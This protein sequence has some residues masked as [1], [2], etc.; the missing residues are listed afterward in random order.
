MNAVGLEATLSVGSLIV[1]DYL[2]KITPIESGYMMAVTK[3]N[4]TQT[5]TVMDGQS[6]YQAAVA[7]G[8]QGTEAEFEAE[9]AK[10]AE[11]ASAEASRVQAEQERQAAEK[12]R[13]TA[14]QSRV[15]AEQGRVTAEQSR[16]AAEAER[17]TAEQSR[18]TAEGARK[19]AESARAAAETHREE[20]ESARATAEAGRAAAE[21]LRRSAET[22]RGTAE[23]GRVTAEQVRTSAEQERIGAEAE[24][25]TAENSRVGAETARVVAEQTR[26]AEFGEMSDKFDNIQVKVEPVENGALITLTDPK[27]VT[28][29]VTISKAD[30]PR[31][32]VSG[33]GGAVPAL[34]RLWDSVGKTST[35]GTDTVAAKSDFDGYAPFNRRRCVGTW[36]LVDGKPVFDVAAYHGDADYAEDGSMGD[37]VAV[38]VTPF[39]YYEQDG[40]IGVSEQQFPCWKLHPVCANAD[41]SPRLH[42][43]LPCYTM[44][45][46]DGHAVSLPGYVGQAN[47]YHGLRTTART[48]GDGATLSEFAIIEPGAVN[49][50]E[51]L[52]FTIEFATQNCQSIMQGAC[53]MFFNDGGNS[54]IVTAPAAN[55]VV[56]NS[57]ASSLVIGQNI[58]IASGSVWTARNDASALNRITAIERC[59]EDGAVDASGSCYLITYDGTD[60]TADITVGSSFLNSYP[61]TNGACGGFLSSIGAVLGHTGSP[62]SNTSGRYPMMY[63]WREN[64]FGNQYST[65]VDLMSARVDEGNEVYHIEWYFLP[66]P[67]KY[68]PGDSRAPYLADLQNEEKGWVKLDVITPNSSYA[69]GYIRKEEADER[70]PHIRVPVLTSGSST[71]YYCDYAYLVNARVVCAVR[72]SGDL[73]HGVSTGFRCVIA[74]DAPSDGSWYCGGGLYFVQ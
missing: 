28:T 42:T 64:V 73:Y 58:I 50:Y 40:I 23:Q 74:I 25:V 59:T 26:Q 29:S 15:T 43:Y 6:A 68:M 27:G 13:A 62:I 1:N 57:A 36:E 37:Y 44:G 61:W 51:W 5:M 65:S 11:V 14:E 8:Y 70:F 66:D 46:K 38:D 24:R 45:S 52:L 33:V 55:K 72:R 31:F 20:E 19:N 60:R 21:T 34:T 4:E 54:L 30:A 32:G 48:Y 56:M 12:A 22:A 71:T 67:T 53:G 7:A 35:P 17:E 18:E 63:R 41:G 39:Y 2:I 16:A 3:G 49:H 69:N 9:M 47:S 10:V